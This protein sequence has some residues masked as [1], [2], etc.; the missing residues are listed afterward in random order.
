MIIYAIF[1]RT[2]FPKNNDCSLGLTGV[3]FYARFNGEIRL[4]G[5]PSI[6][7]LLPVKSA[8]L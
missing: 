2:Y 5:T 4:C 1:C 8:E 6:S 3:T 7:D